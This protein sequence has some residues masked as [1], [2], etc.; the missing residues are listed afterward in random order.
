MM[1]RDISF[2]TAMENILYDKML[3]ESAEA[4]LSGEAIRFWEAEKFFIVLGKISKLQEDVNIEAARKDNIE[5]VR[6]IS[7]GGTVIQ[8]PGCLN[9]SFI[10]SYQRNPLFKDIRKSYSIILNKI[11]DSLKNLDI[12]ARFEPISDITF[13]GKKFS[14]NAQSRKKRYMLHHGTILYDFP[15]K[16]VERYLKIPKEQPQYRKG[17][18]HGDFLTNIKADPRE[19]KDKIAQAFAGTEK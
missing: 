14:G 9:Y 18:A 8:G 12:E 5:I 3:L 15:L 19:I 2:P 7:G 16:M 6:R 13:Y 10:F 4:G 17:R 1:V 11:C